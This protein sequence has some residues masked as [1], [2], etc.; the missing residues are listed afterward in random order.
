MIIGSSGKYY[1]S[2]QVIDNNKA[3]MHCESAELFLNKNNWRWL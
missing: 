3:K 1:L 2:H